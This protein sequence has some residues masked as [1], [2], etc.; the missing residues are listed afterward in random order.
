MFNTHIA[1]FGVLLAIA[2]VVVVLSV[3]ESIR[4]PEAGGHSVIIAMT[5]TGVAFCC[6]AGLYGA[7]YAAAYVQEIAVTTGALVLF[8]GLLT[9]AIFR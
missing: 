1:L 6:G 9:V 2:S 4:R 8:V 3:L 5:A 7:L